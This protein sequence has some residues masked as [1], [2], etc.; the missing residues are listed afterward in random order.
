VCCAESTNGHSTKLVAALNVVRAESHSQA[1]Q[2]T[3]VGVVVA[4]DGVVVGVVDGTV[5]GVVVGVV[6]AGDVVAG[7][8]VGVPV[9]PLMLMYH[10]PSISM[11]GAV[12]VPLEPTA[13][14]Y[15]SLKVPAPG[16]NPLF[17]SL[18]LTQ[19]TVVA[20]SALWAQTLPVS[21]TSASEP[22]M[23]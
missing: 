12:V 1:D 18:L 9:F 4:E 16:G 3:V 6:V 23:T 14:A 21:A 17:G 20:A 15:A 19:E 7:E 13:A 22:S 11:H 10:F 2:G 5:V 8:V